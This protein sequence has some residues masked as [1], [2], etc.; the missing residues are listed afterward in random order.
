[1]RSTRGKK[2]S[3]RLWTHACRSCRQTWRGPIGWAF[4]S[5]D[6]NGP[7]SAS[8]NQKK[9]KAVC[10]TSINL[11]SDWIC[12]WLDHSGAERAAAEQ[13][14]G[15]PG[16]SAQP[17]GPGNT[18]A[19]S[20]T[21]SH[22][23]DW[24]NCTR[25]HSHTHSK[26]KDSCGSLNPSDLCVDPQLGKTSAVNPEFPDFDWKIKEKKRSFSLVS[27]N[28]K[29]VFQPSHWTVAFSFQALLLLE[30]HR[31]FI[32]TFF[33]NFPLLPRHLSAAPCLWC[34]DTAGGHT[35]RSQS[36]AGGEHSAGERCSED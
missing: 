23:T 27:L 6:C 21:H 30:L 16:G 13:R 1:M 22:T 2:R 19:C 9:L 4:H 34:G 26:N 5:T 15:A 32:S 28:A 33:L 7:Q 10:R 3:W 20:C 18:H 29:S 17:E 12:L 24:H 25:M 8:E 14:P 11:W 36:G 31:C 35:E